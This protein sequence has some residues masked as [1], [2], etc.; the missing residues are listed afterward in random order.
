MR[1]A[2]SL[3]QARPLRCH[4]RYRVFRARRSRVRREFDARRAV[5]RHEAAR[6]EPALRVA[7]DAQQLEAR[8]TWPSIGVS[9]APITAGP[10]CGMRARTSAA[11]KHLMRIIAKFGLQ[12]REALDCV[13]GEFFVVE[14]EVEAA[15]AASGRRTMPP[16]LQQRLREVAASAW[17]NC[18]TTAC[19][20]RQAVTLALDPDEA[21]IAA[22]RAKAAVV[23]VQRGYARAFAGESVGVTA[24]PTRP[25][26]YKRPRPRAYRGSPAV[27]VSVVSASS[28]PECGPS[29]SHAVEQNHPAGPCATISTARH[30]SDER[31][32][33][34]GDLVRTWRRAGW[35]CPELRR[36]WS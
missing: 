29:P 21:E 24:E 19:V 30:R 13:F 20:W 1:F 33:R 17:P 34:L 26:A 14:A 32:D 27:L 5:V 18:A 31:I 4:D 36:R 10:T 22:R 3:P 15:L 8:F 11:S 23:L 35:L 6:R 25:A 9:L 16:L 2:E 12:G 7:A 28:D